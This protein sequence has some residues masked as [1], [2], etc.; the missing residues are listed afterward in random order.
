L[1]KGISV[2][3]QKRL[4]SQPLTVENTGW[5]DRAGLSFNRLFGRVWDTADVKTKKLG[6]KTRINHARVFTTCEQKL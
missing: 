6:N 4:V 2:C 3:F 1:L 5:L